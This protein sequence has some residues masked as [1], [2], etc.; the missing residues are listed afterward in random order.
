MERLKWLFWPVTAPIVFIQNHFKATLLVLIVLLI[1]FSAEKPAPQ[2]NLY[3]IDLKG[4][5]LEADGF[6]QEV[7]AAKEE[8]V[9]GVLLVVDSPGGSVP[10]SVEMMMAIKELAAQKPVVAYSAGVMASGSYYA[11]IWSTE[12]IANPGS[13]VGS[14]GVI[15]EGVNAAELLSKIGVQM[16]VVK[17][18]ELKEAGTFYRDWTADE[19]AQLNSVTDAIYAMFVQDVAEARE[20]NASDAP[21]FANG[22]IFTAPQALG[23]GL[24]DRL[25]SISDAEAQLALLSGVDEPLWNEKDP[26]ERF[27]EMLEKRAQ[28]FAI[29]L[30]SPSAQMRF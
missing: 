9:K 12:I 4:P 29:G 24:V 23:H 30:L 3:R 1:V 10:P 2:P 19:R 26:M 11:S 16:N 22:R 7:A 13:V 6:L 20:L 15:M 21:A 27:F 28:A 18:G 5:I 17:A 25:G 14:I 8:N